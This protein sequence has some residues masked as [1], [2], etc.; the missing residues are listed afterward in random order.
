[1]HMHVKYHF[2]ADFLSQDMFETKAYLEYS[3]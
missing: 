3:K 2:L 1:M